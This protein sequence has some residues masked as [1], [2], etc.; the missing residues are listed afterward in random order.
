MECFFIVCILWIFSLCLHE[1]GHAFVAYR[2]GDHT[3][4]EK[5]YLTMNPLRYLHPFYSLVMPLLFVVMG[6]IGLPGGAVYI[7]RQLLRSRGWDT[8]VSLAGPATNLVLILVLGLLF[9][10]GV[11]PHD[12]NRLVTISLAFLF[13]LEVGCLLL[14]LLPIPPLDGFQ[15]LAP[16]LPPELRQQ[17]MGLSNMGILFVFLAI[18]FIPSVN[19]AFWGVVHNIGTLFDV[20]PSWGR[21]GYRA[22]R[23]WGD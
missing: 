3:V 22:F 21:L 19:M 12:G 8:A 11:I 17:L 7:E 13:Q 16:W 5:G 15:A 9:K 2:G 14:C 1:F 6:G 4:V 23:F 18:A 10:T 20:A